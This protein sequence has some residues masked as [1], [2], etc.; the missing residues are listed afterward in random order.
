MTRYLLTISQRSD[1]VQKFILVCFSLSG[2]WQGVD[3][4]FTAVHHGPDF[5]NLDSIIRPRDGCPLGL[6]VTVGAAEASCVG[7]IGFH[8]SSLHADS[9]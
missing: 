5:S 8:L 9:A 3:H 1:V 7:D 2:A 6:P 4:R